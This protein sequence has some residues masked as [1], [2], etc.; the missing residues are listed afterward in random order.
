[1]NIASVISR[2]LALAFA[3]ALVVGG[4][5]VSTGIANGQ[6]ADMSKDMVVDMSK[7]TV[8]GHIA[9][10]KRCSGAPVQVY[11]TEEYGPD[12]FSTEILGKDPDKVVRCLL[13][14]S[15]ATADP[16]PVVAESDIVA[17]VLPSPSYP[18]WNPET[19]ERRPMKVVLI[20]LGSKLYALVPWHSAYGV[21]S[22]QHVP[23]FSGRRFHLSTSPCLQPPL[24]QNFICIRIAPSST[25]HDG[26]SS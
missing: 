13:L 25:A 7:D 3:L 20:R 5:I 1:M 22:L 11:R 6:Q 14:A 10:T 21:H 19:G 2:T 15:P 17:L 16:E 8:R 9:W 12:I 23:S 26:R 4:L 18:V 24:E